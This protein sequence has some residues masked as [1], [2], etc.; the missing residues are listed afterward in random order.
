MT[1][2]NTKNQAS[3]T[4]THNYSQSATLR[5]LQLPMQV[6]HRGR[7]TAT[8]CHAPAPACCTTWSNF[9]SSPAC[10]WSLPASQGKVYL[11]EPNSSI[12][13]GTLLLIKSFSR[14]VSFLDNAERSLTSVYWREA[15][16]FSLLLDVAS[17]FDLL[18]RQKTKL[19]LWCFPIQLF[20]VLGDRHFAWPVSTMHTVS[21]AYA[22]ASKCQKH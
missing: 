13:I 21:Q 1:P 12:W 8:A 15:P 10:I 16:E 4:Y 18:I 14:S 3:R 19:Q 9:W 17:P 7:A 22:A 2:Q 20:P 11:L 6:M 5:P